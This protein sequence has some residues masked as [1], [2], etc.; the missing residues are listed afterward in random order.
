MSK[1]MV[2]NVPAH[3]HTN[4]TLPVV[5][6][7]V[8]RGHTVLYYNG[9]EMCG[10]IEQTGVDFRPYNV[11]L[12]SSKEISQRLRRMID[13]ALIFIELSEQLT[14]LLLAEAASEQ[15]DVI[16]YDSAAAWGYITG[17]K[18]HV[19]HVCSI[20]TFVLDGARGVLTLRDLGTHLWQALPHLPRILNWQREMRRRYG[21]AHVGGIT[22]YGDLN[23][24]FTSRDFQPE[25]SRI[26]DTFRFVGPSIDPS[27]RN[28]DFPFNV[29]DG[30]RL[31]Y[32]SL[33]TVHNLDVT[34]YR[35]VFAAFA[36][37]PAQFVL[38]AGLHSDASLLGEV[39]A[40][41]VVR[42][43]VPQLEILQRAHAFITHGGINSVQE[44]LYYGVPQIVVP[45]QFEQ[46]INARQVVR[47]G[48]GILLG[49]QPPYGRVSTAQLRGALDRILNESTYRTNAAQVGQ[50]LRD[51]GGT[52]RAVEEIEAFL[53]ASRPT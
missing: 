22:E 2:V 47:H 16:I 1:I 33:G 27:M 37:Y 42:P 12:P 46:L 7:L 11:R 19:R 52:V 35:T 39:P 51:A 34:F 49:G 21:A 36:D 40:N 38:A 53:G 31:V 18:L 10:K 20:T 26:D 28:E 4:P 6:E 17:R 45:H 32:I 24:V 3:G 8:A 25:S 30:R 15:P 43:H 9:E 41:F 44:G 48:S 14:P 50:T 13:G 29:L 5:R 23:L